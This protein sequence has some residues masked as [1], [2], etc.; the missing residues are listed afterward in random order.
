MTVLR[1]V[2]FTRLLSWGF[3]LLV[4][5]GLGLALYLGVSGARTNTR[6][7]LSELSRSLMDT[8]AAQV[9]GQLRPVESQLQYLAHS[10]ADAGFVV[11]D[12]RAVSLLFDGALAATPQVLGIMLLEA[13]RGRTWVNREQH[14]VSI[15]AWF[16]HR[17]STLSPYLEKPPSE[18][19]WL[20]PVWSP[21]LQRLV[22]PR[23]QP[24]YRDQQFIG[25]IV[26][27][28]AIDQLS[29]FMAQLSEQLSVRVFLLQGQQRVLAY[30][31]LQ[32]SELSADTGLPRLDQIQDSLLQRFWDPQR[33]REDWLE[34][35]DIQSY[36]L[37]TEQG[38]MIFLLRALPGY[39][40][41]PWMVGAYLP[42]KQISRELMRLWRIVVV[43]LA[44]LLVVLLASAVIS[45]RIGNVV[46]RTVAGFEAIRHQPLQQIKALPPSRIDEFDQVA[47]AYNRMLI[48]LRRSETSQQLFGRYVPEAIAKQLLEQQ[49]E[50]Q[51]Q[52]CQGTV[53]FCD[54]EGFTA[55]SQRLSPERL[56]ETLN[57]YF[58]MVVEVIEAHQG[59]VT[60]FQGDAVLAIFNIP[61]ADPQHA[62][63]AALA[64]QA[65]LRHVEQRQFCGQR[66]ACRIGINSG[67]LVAG[68]VGARD[69]LSYT[70]H[71]DAVNLAARL[72]AINK[73]YG[74]RLLIS[75]STAE[76]LDDLALEWVDDA[77][78]RGRQGRIKIFRPVS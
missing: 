67:E 48:E 8:V 19:L 5:V 66:L 57:A 6:A 70:V 46:K 38:D 22:L 76:Q 45:R 24:V 1:R 32:R 47:S 15:N 61:L 44:L 41:E 69:R 58:S 27:T 26:A 18:P 40:A 43:G 7:L 33:Q 30:P 25:L 68:S 13:D 10:L 60:Q 12:K 16:E 39:T 73:D 78:V 4:V 34:Q 64:G 23:L 28:I 11:A 52:R 3:G 35:G 71:G 2:T 77:E 9:D 20:D 36:R 29:D 51:P 55:L 75:E 53:L 63:H 72:E 37:D 59:V 42:A 56:V 50:L 21:R 65:I 74:T 54:L 31:G 62:L 17:S 49:G 14:Q